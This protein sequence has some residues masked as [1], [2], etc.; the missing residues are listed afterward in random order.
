MFWLE[1][2][3][4]KFSCNFNRNNWWNNKVFGFLPAP[5]PRRGITTLFTSWRFDISDK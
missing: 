3:R 4:N 5:A 2:I 1:F